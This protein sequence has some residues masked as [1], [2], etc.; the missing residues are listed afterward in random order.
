MSKSI[1]IPLIF[2]FLADDAMA[3]PEGTQNA[4]DSI[5]GPVVDAV[6]DS[7]AAAVTS[8]GWSSNVAL[9][10]DDGDD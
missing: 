1:I 6:V 2:A 10:D 7:V 4:A 9:G 3:S 5:S 8:V